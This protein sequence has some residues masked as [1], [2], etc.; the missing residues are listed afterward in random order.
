MA[1]GTN[2]ELFVLIRPALSRTER[3]AGAPP[4]HHAPSTAWFAVEGRQW[5]KRLQDLR[6]G[7]VRAFA[8]FDD[9]AAGHD[10]DG[11]ECGA[12]VGQKHRQPGQ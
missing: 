1:C 7:S 8:C 10:D 3:P 12:E 11:R 5:R 9:L 6:P 2:R 4:A